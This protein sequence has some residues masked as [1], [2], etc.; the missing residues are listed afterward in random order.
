MLPQTPQSTSHPAAGTCKAVLSTHPAPL[1]HQSF[2]Q[3]PSN[4]GT[5]TFTDGAGSR[6]N[7]LSH[8]DQLTS[9]NDAS[10][11]EE[12]T[13][14]TSLAHAAIT[15]AKAHVLPCKGEHVYLWAALIEKTF[16]TVF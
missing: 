4:G 12:N 15:Q 1:P 8:S 14:W 16:Y 3:P 5:A 6:S 7:S 13:K 2:G 11:L 9:L 10:G